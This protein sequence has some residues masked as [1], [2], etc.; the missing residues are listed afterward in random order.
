MLREPS[1]DLEAFLKG[2][3]PDLVRLALLAR[4]AILGRAP[5]CW[6]LLYETYAVS[7][8]FSLTDELKHAFCHV[9]VY[10][11][12]VNLGFNHGTALNDSSG[13][14]SGTGK[15]IRHI[16]L[17][18]DTDLDTGPVAN[19]IEQAIAHMTAHMEENGETSAPGESVVKQRKTK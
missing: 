12:H 6:E 18:P 16:R 9:A 8:A 13:V 3:D 2:H 17:S 15:L 5:L 1:A 7:I 11:K 10:A 14:L 19:L 4:D